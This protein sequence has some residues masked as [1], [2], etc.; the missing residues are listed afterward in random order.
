V[1]VQPTVIA[2]ISD[3]HIKAFGRLSY[4]QVDTHA[5]LLQVI[6]TLNALQPRPDVVVITGDLVDF[7]RP[8]EYQT[9][10]E[11]LQR[12]QLP[13]YL[14]AGNHDNREALRAAFPDHTYLQAGPTLNWQLSVG[15]VRLL[16]LDSSVPQ[17]PWGEVDEQQLQWLDQALRIWIGNGYA[18]LRHLRRSLPAIRRLSG[19]FVV[20]CIAA[21]RPA[22]P[23][24]WPVSHPACRIR[25]LWICT[26]RGRLTLFW[27]RPAFCSI[28]GSQCREWS[29][30]SARLATFRDPGHFTIVRG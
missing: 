12:L 26:R 16:A 25:W 28:A 18:I 30:I 10:R 13:F 17:Q 19:C 2:Q 1:S 4:K 24:P 15:G 11:A 22:L 20:I 29:R 3:L 9:L 5:A 7:G 27:S 8:E 14:M 23:E 6:D 21:C